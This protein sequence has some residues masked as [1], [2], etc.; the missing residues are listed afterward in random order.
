M[1]DGEQRTGVNRVSGREETED[2]RLDRNYAE[3]LQE[4]R[5][6]QTGTQILFAFLLTAALSGYMSEAGPFPRIVLAV[7]LVLAALANALLIAPAVIHRF[8]FH[9]HLRQRLVEVS[10]R[11]AQGALILVLGA[12]VGTCLLALDAVLPRALAVTVTAGVTAWFLCFWFA[13][14]LVLR[15][16]AR[17]PAEQ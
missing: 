1:S 7:T 16:G 10:S 13:L 14:P 8:V 11:L 3:I 6:A 12:V 9:R 15:R 2:E 5:V 4:L 17:E